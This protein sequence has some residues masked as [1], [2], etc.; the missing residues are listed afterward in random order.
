MPCGHGR[1]RLATDMLAAGF[2][3]IRSCRTY[4]RSW[5]VSGTPERPEGPYPP[6]VEGAAVTVPCPHDLEPST[7]SICLHGPSQR[8]SEDTTSTC[9]TCGA[10]I[11]WVVTEKGK[12]MPL[13]A[14]PHADG[15]FIKLRLDPDGSKVVHFLSVG[16]QVANTKPTYESHFSTC[17]EADLHRRRR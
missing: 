7:C 9:K 13:D 14:D 16:E 4:K 1:C 5:V 10:E 17:P 2:E 15:R 3:T 8:G 6:D 11:V 12:R